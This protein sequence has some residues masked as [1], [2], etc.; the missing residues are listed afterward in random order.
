LFV[1]RDRY[2]TVNGWIG[3][4]IRIYNVSNINTGVRSGFRISPQD[5]QI[6]IAESILPFV[7][8]LLI[9]KAK[10][11]NLEDYLKPFLE[12]LIALQI[13]GLQFKEIFFI[14]LRYLP[15]CVRPLLEHFLKLLLVILDILGVSD[16]IRKSFTTK[17][18][19]AYTFF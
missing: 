3:Q 13:E 1:N 18:I 4:H 5:T 19:L 17:Y 2:E 10:P 16:A 15:S 7:V 14:Q 8:S 9:G 11:A 12:E 6:S